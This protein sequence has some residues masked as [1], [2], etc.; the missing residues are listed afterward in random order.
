[1][2]K[3][4][5]KTIMMGPNIRAMP[6]DIIDVDNDMGRHLVKS[7]SAELIKIIEIE[8][9]MIQPV[10]NAMLQKPKGRKPR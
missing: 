8:T 2:Y 1:M 5:M 4:K 9:A 6:G 10:E 7:G 3:V